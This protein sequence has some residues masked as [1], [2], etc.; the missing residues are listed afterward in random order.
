[1]SFESALSTMIRQLPALATRRVDAWINVITGLGS[2]L[3]DKV[4]NT[5]PA[6]FN[7][8]LADQLLSDLFHNDATVRKIVTKRP[9]EALRLGMRLS[10]PKDAGGH[11]V[12]T[13]FQDSFDD[14]DV[15]GTFVRACAWEN[16][17]GGSVIFMAL[18]DG[19]TAL[20]S[21]AQP[22]RLER[23]ERVLWLKAIDK[24]RIRPSYDPG[25]VDQ[26]EASPTYGQPLIYLLDI[27]LTGV[28]LRIH[29]SRLIIFP[30]ILTTDYERRARGGWGI[31]MLD[32]VFEVLQR[33]T[34]AWQSAGNAL[35]N[36]QYV[37]YKLKGLAHMFSR[38][39][40]EAMAK[41]RASAMELAK[42]I[43]NAVLVDAEDEYIRE[44]PNFGNMPQMLDQF[45]LDVASAVD[46]PATVLWGRSPAGM[47]ATGESD[48][49]IWYSGCDDYREHHIRPR[50]HRLV[51]V[52]MAAR[53]GPT[54]GRVFDGWRVIF[55]ALRQV[56]E[57]VK[58]DIRLKT[59]QADASDI[60]Q[61]ILLP[62]EVAVSR[63]RP[64]GYSQETQID[65]DLRE[66]LLKIEI[67]QREKELKEGR[68]PGQ[69]PPEPEPALPGA[70]PP[71]K[72]AA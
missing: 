29:R 40:G 14:L 62:Q 20:D 9:Q 38:T 55:P 61:G 46:Y 50:G 3:T 28:Q 12:A 22:V 33:N 2:T 21:Q 66:R 37:V 17:Y 52:L 23:L 24:T 42:S 72:K 19:Q 47:N 16:L 8:G 59:S 41:K 49:E 71:A 51:E 60:T 39:D 31:S 5:L 11:E 54:Q 56:S 30:G 27:Q 45:M 4:A 7:H 13:A 26:D 32:P 67:E 34:T 43:I 48:L 68:G 65:L 44:N 1:M 57:A 58:A 25:D 70:K 63:F 18:D 10:V 36:A 53:Q 64:E 69:N 6:P 15:V 35:A